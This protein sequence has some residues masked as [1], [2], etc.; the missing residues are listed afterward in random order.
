MNL[1]DIKASIKTWNGHRHGTTRPTGDPPPWI[2]DGTMA[3]RSE[4][5]TPGRLRKVMAKVAELTMGVSDDDVA[6]VVEPNVANCT[7]GQVVT[8]DGHVTEKDPNCTAADYRAGKHRRA[9]DSHLIDRV[10]FTDGNGLTVTLD[11]HRVAF[12]ADYV[13]FDTVRAHDP[14]CAVTLYRDGTAVAILM[15]VRLAN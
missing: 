10:D 9:R 15:P 13:K 5:V 12:L 8:T 4:S 11:A 6:R 3:F 14:L 1:T 2:T 7:A